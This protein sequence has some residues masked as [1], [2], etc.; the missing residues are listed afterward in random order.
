M[1]TRAFCSE[2]NTQE[3]LAGTADTVGAW[4]LLEYRPVWKAKAQQDNDLA[5]RTRQW[6][7]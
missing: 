5:P 6:P 3:P 4:L 1:E 7:A 2:L